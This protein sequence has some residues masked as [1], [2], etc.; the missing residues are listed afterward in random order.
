MILI[1]KKIIILFIVY[2]NVTLLVLEISKRVKTQIPR[3]YIRICTV[4]GIA[5]ARIQKILLEGVQLTLFVFVFLVDEGREDKNTTKSGHH[6]P[7]S[8]TPL[9]LRFAG[10]PMMAQHRMLA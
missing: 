5:H 2:T 8:E 3:H 9:K 10:G 1:D 7:S 6:R 4:C